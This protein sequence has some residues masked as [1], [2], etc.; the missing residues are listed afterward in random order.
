MAIAVIYKRYTGSA[1][2]ELTFKPSSHSHTIS[3]I[4]DFPTKID[5][6]TLD[7]KHAS[8]F[9]SIEETS[10]LTNYTNVLQMLVEGSTINQ[11]VEDNT[12]SYI[13]DVPYKSSS[14]AKIKEIGGMCYKINQ[15]INKENLPSTAT[16]HGI[17]VTNNGNGSITVN[18]TAT[19]NAYFHIDNKA[20]EST[21]IGHKY[22]I[23]GG[24]TNALL[25]YSK[26]GYTE[27]GNGVIVTR[28]DTDSGLSF[29]DTSIILE[30]KSGTTCNNVIVQPQLIDLTAVYGK[31][32]EPTTVAQFLEDYPMFNDY[33]PY[34]EGEV[35]ETKVTSID[36]VGANIWDEEWELGSINQTTGQNEIATNVIRSKNYIGVFPNTAY[37]FKSTQTMG[38]RYYDNNKN[39]IGSLAINND[40]KAIPNNCAYV[41]FVCLNTT[42]YNN[43]I[44][45]IKGTS[46]TYTPYKH[47]NY[48]INESIQSL[49]GYGLGI[50]ASLYNYIDFEN[51][52]FI[53]KVGKYTFNG[54]EYWA[55]SSNGNRWIA[56]NLSGSLGK[57]NSNLLTN[58]PNIVNYGNTYDVNNSIYLGEYNGKITI[59]IADST[60]LPST[61][62][63]QEVNNYL[64]G[65]SLYY[66]LATQEEID[67]SDILKDDAFIEVE[68]KGSITFENEKQYAV[69]NNVMFFIKEED[70]KPLIPKKVSE[71]ENDSNF[72][73]LVDNLIPSQYLPSYVDDVL[74]YANMAELPQTGES[75]KIYIDKTTNKTYRWSGT[76]YVE[77]SPSLALGE[78]S[79]TA[80]AGDKGKANATAIAT[81]QSYFNSDGVALRAVND[82]VGNP[83]TTSYVNIGTPQTITGDKSFS[84]YLK[85]IGAAAE[86]HLITRGIGGC[87]TDTTTNDDLYVNYGTDYGLKFGKSG[88]GHLKSDGSISVTGISCSGS[89]TE[90]GTALSSKYQTKGDYA[91]K[92][93]IKTGEA[94][95]TWG[96]KNFFASYGPIDAAMIP[97][98]GANRMAFALARGITVEYSRNGGETWIDYGLSDIHKTAIFS[99]PMV[100]FGIVIGKPTKNTSTGK[101]ENIS[102]NNRARIIVDTNSL[103]GSNI[104]TNLNKFVIYASTSGSTGCKVTIDGQT[105]ANSD[106]GNDTWETFADADIGG[107]AG[108]NVIN[109]SSIITY[110]NTSAQYTKLRFTFY[111]LGN[112]SMETYGGLQIINIY[113]FGGVGWSIPSNMARW[114]N[115]YTYDSNQN[116]IFPASIT[117]NNVLPKANNSYYLGFSNNQ[118]L[119]AYIK[120]IYEDGTLLSNKYLGINANAV[121]ATKSNKL[122]STRNRP[123]SANFDHDYINGYAS[124]TLD[125]ASGLMTEGKPMNE[126]FIS[127]Y[128]WDNNG[129]WD[130]QLYIPLTTLRRPQIRFKENSAWS[131]WITI[132]YMSDIPTKVSQL[133]ND[134]NYLAKNSAI[135]VASVTASGNIESSNGTISGVVVEG[136][137][138]K[139]NGRNLGEIYQL[140]G[141]Y[142]S[143]SSVSSLSQTVDDLDSDVTT[144]Q[145][146]FT[147][148]VAKQAA[149]ANSVAWGNVTGK[150]SSYTPSSH[151]HGNITNDG[152]LATANQVVVTDANKKI[153]SVAKGTAFN[154]NFGTTSGTVS[155]GN[156]THS[157]ATTS[158]N[159][160]MSSAMVTQLNQATSDLSTLSQTVDTLDSDV[161]AVEGEITNIKNNYEKKKTTTIIF[162]TLTSLNTNATA[163]GVFTSKNITLTESVQAGDRLK[164]YLR[165]NSGYEQYCAGII[166]FELYAPTSSKLVGSGMIMPTIGDQKFIVSASITSTTSTSTSLSIVVYTLSKTSG[167]PAGANNVNVLKVERIR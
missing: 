113:G 1:W 13:K 115:I 124:Q 75:G 136:E 40:A 37:Y 139:E 134:S 90:N 94:F 106:A 103:T 9:S 14:I 125:I 60:N 126:G 153:T 140:K 8:D 35:T 64:K 15:L 58:I 83:I 74:E 11:E 107:W 81:L 97:S 50:N 116:A 73:A 145:G 95:L 123:T 25:Y 98:L 167:A 160:L 92:S 114:G 93:D 156:H 108:Y 24:S 91:L 100:N 21:I 46:G 155:E 135:S 119:N 127:T 133:T 5:A 59:Q 163:V 89:I 71:L 63:S 146:Y 158:A 85:I 72:V 28:S 18:G 154:K 32:K 130:T 84:G 70:S 52:K 10:K 164:V 117:A 128:F 118:W 149:S 166:E 3:E 38:L 43:D 61:M 4:S 57:T 151:T 26:S 99:G 143:A 138:V 16:S 161:S 51:K 162:N 69:P 42:T 67:L 54:S 159:G 7:G 111:C 110:G 65:K 131:D 62:T 144:L 152:L 121:S 56:I 22:L 55:Y 101:Y 147:N 82:S 105:K 39:Y 6:D 86:R 80:Y 27:N 19:A 29:Y 41:R 142:A 120:N 47:K 34:N 129:A 76:T 150:P 112:Q 122:V 44:A 132:P 49:D 109:T 148:G 2:E 102:V 12:K 30:V 45:I 78:T 88:E 17:T 33:V 36:C 165:G 96:G 79:S 53:K 68:S 141:S 104:Y 20:H 87:S 137:T 77:I 23:K 31:G 48:P 157:V 66:E